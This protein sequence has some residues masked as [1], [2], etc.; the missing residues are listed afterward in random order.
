MTRKILFLLSVFFLFFSFN[1][2]LAIDYYVSPSGNDRN[3]GTS[4]QEAWKTTRKVNNTNFNAGD[5]IFFEGSQTF[6]GG[7]EF[8]SSD[9]GTSNNPVTLGSYGMGRATIS[10]NSNEGLYVLNCE[11][12]EVK[13]LIFEGSGSNRNNVNG[14][15]FRSTLGSG[16]KLEHIRIDNVDVSGYHWAGILVGRYGEGGGFKD[17][18]ITNSASHDNADVGINVS[19]K[20]ME[21]T[22]EDVYVG[23][24]IA[25]NNRGI[26]G[27][28]S[29]S[30]SGILLS[31]V[32][33]A[34][35][36]HCESYNNGELCD[37][38][39]GG[40]VGIWAWDANNLIIQFCESHHNKSVYKDGGGF[41]LDG[42]CT[43]CFM[44]YNFSHDNR[45][46]GYMICQFSYSA[47]LLNNV[48]R[49]NITQDDGYGLAAF[50]GD[51][52]MY[53]NYFYNNTVYNSKTSAVGL[54][55]WSGGSIG[56][57]KFYNNIF[58]S[59]P[60]QIIGMW[61]TQV[62]DAT[63]KGNCYWG[64]DGSGFSVDGYND[65][66]AWA[67]STNQEKI[68][69]TIV[70]MWANPDFVDPG[71]DGIIGDP[72]KLDSLTTYKL[73]S[74]LQVINNGLDLQMLFSINPGSH[75]YYGIKIPIDYQY[76]IGAS[77]YG[78]ISDINGDGNVNLIDYAFLA[79]QWT[80]SPSTPSADIE[81][82]YGDGI[83]DFSDLSTFMK[84]WLIA[85]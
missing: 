25:Y 61:G 44:Q 19:G 71:N 57:P 51:D 36:E 24:C 3:S 39:G 68:G 11:G 56:N 84:N 55:E 8:D 81:P 50:S 72:H 10:S 59:V 69:S 9:S 2:A 67:N 32:D 16:T 85:K 31:Q 20:W 26:A 12:F 58:Y 62:D 49:Y 43:N 70:G 15:Y 7:L 53:D 4:P 38:T 75:D 41:D 29:H 5:S 83:V 34:T 46:P 47:A 37:H 45:G 23:D 28:G 74:N 73:K 48:C 80:Q 64:V 40:P 42:G 76:D 60:D 78:F 65:F 1:P 77:E 14:V 33:V 52:N 13:N 54:G 6:N 35:I 66:D 18:R 82:Y 22:H 27:K 30:G 17:V 21:L 79:Y 63:F